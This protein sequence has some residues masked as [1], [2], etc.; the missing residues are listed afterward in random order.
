VLFL[1]AV[2]QGPTSVTSLAAF[3]TLPFPSTN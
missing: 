2:S 1:C 3:S